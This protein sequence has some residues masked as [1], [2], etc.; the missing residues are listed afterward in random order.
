MG[1]VSGL[2]TFSGTLGNVDLGTLGSGFDFS[3]IGSGSSYG[4]DPSAYGIGGNQGYPQEQTYQPTYDPA[5]EYAA[6]TNTNNFDN[7]GMKYWAVPQTTTDRYGDPQTSYSYQMLPAG[8][9]PEGFN[10]HVGNARYTAGGTHAGALSAYDLGNID[11]SQ[12]YQGYGSGLDYATN[13]NSQYQANQQPVSTN[14]Y[15]V[16]A[17][18]QGLL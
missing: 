15:Y 18:Y 3:G 2:P 14:P 8:V 17:Q 6:T 7:S 4:I 13:L 12:P 10:Y 16:A 11:M 1:A 5:A 9:I